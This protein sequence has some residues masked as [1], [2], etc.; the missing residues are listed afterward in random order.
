MQLG[1]GVRTHQSRSYRPALEGFLRALT[2]LLPE[3]EHRGGGERTAASVAATGPRHLRRPARL[4]LWHS[5]P[6]SSGI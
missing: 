4:S 3:A 5:E 2:D 1:E 6:A